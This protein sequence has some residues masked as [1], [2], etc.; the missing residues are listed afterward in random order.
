VGLLFT[1]I[2]FAIVALGGFG[3]IP[4][5]FFAALIVGLIT[6][7]PGIWD[8]FYYTFGLDWMSAVPVTSLKYTMI[9]AAYFIIMIVRP[10]GLFGWKN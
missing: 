10:R 5:A 8:F 6:E 1:M 7:V 4:G 3:S 9:Y 2:A